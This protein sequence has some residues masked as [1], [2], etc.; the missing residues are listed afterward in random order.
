MQCSQLRQKITS[1][2]RLCVHAGNPALKM[3]HWMKNQLVKE[4]YTEKWE[5]IVRSGSAPA[6]SETHEPTTHLPA[7]FG[8][9]DKVPAKGTAPMGPS[10][11]ADGSQWTERDGNLERRENDQASN[12]NSRFDISPDKTASAR[13]GGFVGGDGASLDGAKSSSNKQT[14]TPNGV[15]SA[16]HTHLSSQQ[17]SE[18]QGHLQDQAQGSGQLPSQG[19]SQPS[20][21]DNGASPQGSRDSSQVDDATPGSNGASPSGGSS[22]VA[23]NDSDWWREVTEA[24]KRSDCSDA[25][26]ALT[27][28]QGQS[29]ARSKPVDDSPAKAQA[30]Q[31]IFGGKSS[32]SDSHTNGARQNGAAHPASSAPASVSSST[33]PSSPSS[34]QTQTPRASTNSSR[35]E[36]NSQQQSADMKKRTAEVEEL[37]SKI[38]G[39]EVGSSDQVCDAHSLPPVLAHLC[40]KVYVHSIQQVCKQVKTVLCTDPCYV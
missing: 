10:D 37:A 9:T 11:Y 36:P 29:K 19:Q 32:R 35:A 20:S 25:A 13:D 5:D 33:S 14:P 31:D 1:A 8:T 16:D 34:A 40:N 30:E 3:Q 28:K 7:E 12:S 22:A 4:S 27:P 17:Q 24:S 23:P 2:Y 6:P 39:Q 26:A 38:E 15:S 21:W 18:L